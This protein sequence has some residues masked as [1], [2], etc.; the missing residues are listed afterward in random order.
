MH[1]QAPAET[2]FEAGIEV[3]VA[4]NGLAAIADEM[5]ISL[6]RAAYSDVTRDQLDFSTAVCD[7]KGRV[8]AQG[9]SLALQLGAIPRLMTLVTRRIGRPEPEDVYLVNHPWEG[10]VHLPDFF[11]VRPIF[12]DKSGEPA[13]YTVIVSHMVDVG[14]RFPGSV[15]SRALSL[16][17]EGLVVPTVPIVRGGELNQP[18]LDLIAANSRTPVAVQGDIRAV[19]GAL[20]NG[21]R[22]FLDL[23][24]RIGGT[25][26]LRQIE[27]LL[28][29]TERATRVA[30]ARDIP[31]GSA[32]ATDCFDDDG[33]GNSNLPIVCRVEKK[34]D[35]LHFDFTGTAPQVASG[36]NCTI[37]DVISSIAFAAHSVFTGEDIPVNDGFYRCLELTVPEGS[38][39]NA[40][41]PAAVG[42]RGSTIR[43]ITDIAMTA[44]AALVPGRLPAIPGSDGVVYV[45]GKTSASEWILNDF[46]HPGWGASAINDG[47]PGLSHP[48]V[49][50]ANIPVEIIEERYP[51]RV[52]S[53]QMKVDSAAPGEFT[54]APAVVR[55]YEALR[56]DTTVNLRVDRSERR[57][58]GVGGGHDGAASRCHVRRAGKSDWESV[59][60]TSTF[61]LNVGDRLRVQLSGGGAF[62]EPRARGAAAIERDLAKGLVT[63]EFAARV[64][65]NRNRQAGA[66]KIEQAVA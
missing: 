60:C 47:V 23:A 21:A 6:I 20:H 2:A 55:E 59:R 13:G 17:E 36:R 52:A 4:R 10:G 57:A 32:T 35:R 62:G 14:G 54:G 12:L 48:I 53:F 1:A 8:I 49:N 61:V 30:F 64:F 29:S 38:M 40:K 37:A 58:A 22:Q 39:I 44:M 31:D 16:W 50:A 42:A 43:R 3:E 45:S 26:L 11:F 66:A 24:R 18:L 34:G 15:S 9:L 27:H 19:L 41:Y 28:E 33:S 65:G 56:D 25:R 7:G 51:I 46:V 63:A 5:A